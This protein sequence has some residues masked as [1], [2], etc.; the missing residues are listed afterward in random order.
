MQPTRDIRYRVGPGS[1]VPC[2]DRSQAN[3][4]AGALSGT[5]DETVRNHDGPL[6]YGGPQP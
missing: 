5:R 4:K 2:Q 3:D 6:D 1:A